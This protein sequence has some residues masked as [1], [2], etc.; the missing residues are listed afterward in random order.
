MVFSKKIAILTLVFLIYISAV[1]ASSFDVN[2]VP[3]KNKISID[4][5]AKFR[6][7]IK[8]NLEVQDEYRIYT[9][10]FPAWD[11]RADPISN[12]IT[13]LLAGKSNGSVEIIVDPLKIKEIG[14]YQVGVNIR[15]GI[16]DEAVTMP[17]KVTIL[18]IDSLIQGYVPT[19]I[20]G[21]EIPEEIDPREKV[22]VK[23][24]LNNQNIIDYPDLVIKL[25]SKLIKDT[26]NMQLG[27]KEDKML[28]LEFDI[29]PL[30]PPQ[31]DNLVVAVF[32]GNRSIV[33]PIV[34]RIEIKEYTGHKLVNEEKKFLRTISK[35]SFESN[36][37]N[38][39][40]AFKVETTLFNSIFSSTD[41]QAKIAKENGKRYFTWDVGLENNTMQF[42]VTKNFIPLFIAILMLIAVA[43]AYYVLRSPL[44]MLKESSNI[45]KREGG[46]SEMTVVL[47]I[48]NRSKDKIN[49]IEVNE[50]IPGLVTIGSDVPI[51]S[52]QPTKVMVHEKKGTTVVKWELDTLNASEER[53]LSYRLKSKLA[54]LGSFSL[55]AAKATFKSNNKPFSSTSNRLSVNE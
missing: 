34:K 29:D 15:S 31:E 46:I 17:L 10:D 30:T 52:L 55:P 54:I 48:K 4:E 18:S 38:Y 11:V 51:G 8:N 23:I 45:V 41:P 13:L 2:T 32:K 19:V 42:T 44:Y 37:N 50:Y 24:D 12:P 22:T 16:V 47:H 35:Y 1:F 36:N 27:P 21:V 6:L 25:D 33:N 20:T 7:N 3:I 28:S 26:I 5:F 43:I 53:V 39:N 40:G 9:L 14:S 49:G